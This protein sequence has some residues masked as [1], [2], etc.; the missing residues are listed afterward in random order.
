M[1]SN[2]ARVMGTNWN[3]EPVPSGL[4]KELLHFEG[5]RA[6]QQTA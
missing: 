2:R 4:E 1:P 6:L 3:M 5:D